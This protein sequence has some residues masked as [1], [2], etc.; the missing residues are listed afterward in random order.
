MTDALG[1]PWQR[2]WAGRVEQ[3]IVDSQALT[4]NPLGDPHRRP[5]LVY[6]PPGYD[7]EPERRYPVVYVLQGLGGQVDKWRNRLGWGG[8]VLE[9]T[10][11][12][13]GGESG[14]SPP[15]VIVAY[16]DAWTSLG[17]SQYLDS[18]GTGRYH[19]YLC[20]EVVGFVDVSF[21]T[22]A[23]PAHR[24][25]AG[26]SS[27]GYGALVTAMRRPDL[28]GALASHAGDALF[29]VS[30]QPDLRQASRL[31]R[32][33]YDGDYA[34]FWADL[35]SRPGQARR[36]DEI[37][38]HHWC[39][40]AC[41]STDPDGSVRL[42]FDLA[43]GRL[44][45]E[46]WERWLAHDPVR[47]IPAHAD[48]LRSMRGIWLDAGRADEYYLDLGAEALRREMAAVGVDPGVI[49]FELFEGGHSGIEWRYPLALAWL[50]E[51]ISE[52]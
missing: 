49:R 23:A 37:L 27:G 43:T 26:K 19:T 25:V 45:P 31:L 12:L 8:N 3:R 29:E 52:G 33:R 2:R 7:S 35:R 24:A 44:I 30:Y 32:D 36:G 20:D 9:Q 5:L 4:G 15:P 18:A 13:F 38:A 21:R 34:A 40:S 1:A 16:V 48:A 39:M 46:V 28:F 10:D 47:M 14:P 42:P 51:R 11:A 22:L 6:L 50:A 17:G 41:Y